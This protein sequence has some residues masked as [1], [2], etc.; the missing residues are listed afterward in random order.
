MLIVLGLILIT[1]HFGSSL[2]Y[3]GYC[4]RNAN[5][6]WKLHTD[7]TYAP[8]IVIIVPTYNEELLIVR[9]LDDISDQT[10][11]KD[12][13]GIIVADD[14]SQD[15]TKNLVTKWIQTHRELGVEIIAQASHSGK[16]PMVR[17]VLNRLGQKTDLTILTDVDAFWEHDAILHAARYFADPAIGAVTGSIQYAREKRGDNPREEKTYRKFYNVLRV[18]ESKVF[19]TPISN[20][21]FL[22]LR[23]SSLREY[24]LPDFVGFDDSAIGSF[25]ALA[26][27]RAIQV[28]DVMVWEDARGSLLRRKTR[29]A[30]RLVLN[31]LN[32]KKC[33]IRRG[34]YRRTAFER[35]WK[36]EWWLTLVNPWLLLAG[37]SLLVIDLFTG[38]GFRLALLPLS[39]GVG[40]SFLAPY[41]AWMIQQFYLIAGRVRG[42]M[43]S[44]IT[45]RR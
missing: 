21:P 26:G 25:F 40:L 4:R 45:W 7:I 14:G 17:E 6:P 44:D 24:G 13:L 10:Y 28:E 39:A 1:L 29:R 9:K 2:C 38:Q 12:R 27:L 18:S 11:R 37:A 23:T 31:F 15:R 22:A 5:R 32:T 16:M 41:R 33:A 36:M 43:T 19:S 42:L 3:F 20:G 34:V 30:N 35:I 8:R